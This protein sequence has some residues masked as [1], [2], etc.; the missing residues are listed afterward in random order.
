MAQSPSANEHTY[1]PYENDTQPQSTSIITTHIHNS[2]IELVSS[3]DNAF[4]SQIDAVQ[5]TTANDNPN[6]DWPT[7]SPQPSISNIHT[8]TQSIQYD[9]TITANYPQKT[10]S[11]NEEWL[12]MYSNARGMKGK[13]ASLTC[14][15]NDMQPQLFLLTETQLRSN[16]G[17]TIPNYTFYGKSREKRIGGGVGLLVR[18]D[19]RQ[20]IYIHTS[21]RNLEIIWASVRRKKTHPILIGAYYGKQESRTNKEDIEYEMTMLREEIEERKNDGEIFLAMDANAKIGILGEEISRNGKKILEVFDNTDLTIINTSEKCQGKVTRKNT[22]DETKISAIDF[23]V[24]SHQ[25]EKWISNMKIDEDELI[26]LRGKN[27]SDHNTISINISIPKLDQAKIKP[28]TGWN[29]KASNEK[30]AMF[31]SE[32]IKQKNKAYEI[33]DNTDKPFDTRYKQWYQIID[34]AARQTIGRTTFKINGKEYQSNELKQMHRQKREIKNEIQNEKDKIK[35]DSLIAKYKET[36]ET[37]RNQYIKEKSEMIQEK[38]E[39]IVSDRSKTAFWNLKKKITRDP[40]IESLVVKDENGIRQFDP[41]AQKETYASYYE[42]LFKKKPIPYHPYHDEIKQKILEYSQNTEYDHLDYN[43]LPT[44]NEIKEI[45]EQ[46]KNNK[47]TPD[48]KNEMLKRLG[49]DMVDFIYPLVQAVYRDLCVAKIWNKGLITSLHKGKGDKETLSNHRGITTSS[50][51]GTI[52]DSIIDNRIEKTVP[53][54][55]AQ[56]G[57]KKGMSTCDHLFVLRTIIDISQSQKRE[58]FLTFYD[59]SKA[60]DHVDND[61]LL[62]TMWEKG[63]RGTTWRILQALNTDLSAQVKT[64]FGH[65]REITMEIGGKQGSRLTG[66][67][68][69]KLMD[70]LA[71]E[72]IEAKDGFRITEEFIIAVLLWVDD[73]ISCAE[74]IE[75]QEKMLE[76]V[77][78]F[79][80]KH[81]ITWGAEKCKVMR[82]GRHKDKEKE[83]DWKIGNMAIKEA[84]QYKYL[85]DWITNDGKNKCN[86]EARQRNLQSTTIYINTV[87]SY[88]VLNQIETAVI[89]QLHESKNISSFLTNAQSWNLNKG[90]VDSL[91]RAEIRAIKQLFNLPIHTP[92]I[93]ILY[94]FGLLYTKQRVD[95]IQLIYIHRIMLRNDDDQTKK[96]LINQRT[97]NLGWYKNIHSVLESYKLPTQLEE[98]K[99]ISAPGWKQMVHN[100]I[101][102]KNKERLLGDCYKMNAGQ[103]VPKP[104]TTTLIEKINDSTYTRRPEPEILHLTKVE[105]KTLL[106]ARYGMLEC[107]KNFGGTIGGTC[108][109]CNTHDDETHRLNH[110]T[111]WREINYLDKDEKVDF[112]LVYS[113]D[114]NTLKNVMKKLQ[115]I[116]NTK[117]TPGNMNKVNTIQS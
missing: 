16:V 45:I 93:A 97:F 66:R 70:L 64:K 60:Y 3:S 105:T 54:T 27:D 56:G 10:H 98:I 82:V 116:W 95:K 4:P 5:P 109:Q 113:R 26:K 86:I 48:L 40:S 96:A 7:Q 8:D 84:T 62:V 74:G 92:T 94:T 14:I 28:I 78:Q 101:E 36:Q 11:K 106:I 91:E 88:E 59:V 19:I 73:V 13:I 89:L 83:R 115:P 1:Q 57:G 22:K 37:I 52:F 31:R 71:E 63:L 90:E 34:K 12:I 35:K 29:I 20:N 75:E 76:K 102:K 17:I 99:A 46:K 112:E 30:W 18:N 87:A 81:K 69:A 65:T 85:G 42:S 55:Q 44:R 58:T 80:L 41:D 47:S 6:H 43:A 114:V 24:A 77:N 104:K 110:C 108:G 51:I 25:V 79:A 67:M 111:K 32:I 72:L 39:K 33:M 15:L 68:F 21:N 61:D 107:G 9:D 103:L 2:I 38:F 53:F 23:V 100:A 49:D 117:N 50:S